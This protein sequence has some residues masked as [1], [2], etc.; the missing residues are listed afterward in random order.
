MSDNI[1]DTIGRLAIAKENC[2]MGQ[3]HV[4]QVMQIMFERERRVFIGARQ[5]P[6]NS[7]SIFWN[8][9]QAIERLEMALHDLKVVQERM[10]DDATRKSST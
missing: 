9:N 5:E 10:Q 1:H 8:V 4:S 3:K 6:G 7:A 2:T